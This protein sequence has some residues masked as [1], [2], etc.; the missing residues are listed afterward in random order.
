[1]E[2][3]SLSPE[4][5]S[6]KDFRMGRRRI[7]FRVDLFF[8][9]RLPAARKKGGGF[10]LRHAVFPSSGLVREN[11]SAALKPFRT[12]PF[13]GCARKE[14]VMAEKWKRFVA[15]FRARGKNGKRDAGNRAARRPYEEAAY[16]LGRF[17]RLVHQGSLP[18]RPVPRPFSAPR[19]VSGLRK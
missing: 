16:G 3:E 7:R 2:G 17:F 10:G 8:G 6:P 12:M 15:L 9:A 13:P 14:G 1:M 19:H 4:R 11:V 18:D 5:L